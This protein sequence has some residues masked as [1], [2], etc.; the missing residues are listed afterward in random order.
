M[1][2][3]KN[4]KNLLPECST[5]RP[6][7]RFPVSLPVQDR[8]AALV[9]CAAFSWALLTHI[10]WSL[11][12]R[13]QSTDWLVLVSFSSPCHTRDDLPEATPRVSDLDVGPGTP[14]SSLVLVPGTWGRFLCSPPLGRKGHSL[15]FWYPQFSCCCVDNW[16]HNSLVPPLRRSFDREE[17]RTE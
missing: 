1:N 5:A 6:K 3:H 12:L 17:A 8:I 14:A 9:H 11:A 16:Q 10:V 2:V 7:V 4:C 13:V 15:N